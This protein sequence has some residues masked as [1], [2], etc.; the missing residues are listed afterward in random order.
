MQEIQFLPTG[1]YNLI[2]PG[3]TVLK[4]S[5]APNIAN[6]VLPVIQNFAQMFRDRTA[7]YNT[8]QLVNATNDKTKFQM[9]AELGQI[10]KMTVAASIFFMTPSK[11]YCAKWCAG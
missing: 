4:D 1:P 3:V 8:E 10:A 9:Q 2:T 6:G 5:V 11:F 7:Q